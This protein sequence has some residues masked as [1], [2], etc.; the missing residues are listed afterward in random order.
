MDLELNFKSNPNQYTL[1]DF[2]NSILHS[3][4]HFLNKFMRGVDWIYG[5]HF[6]S[7]SG[8]E[9]R[10]KLKN[11]QSVRLRRPDLTAFLKFQTPCRFGVIQVHSSK[12][13]KIL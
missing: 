6:F 8:K 12:I 7:K 5:P 3:R 4:S 13:F 9:L 10:K 2:S 1:L 11:K